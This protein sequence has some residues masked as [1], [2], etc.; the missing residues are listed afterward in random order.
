MDEAST[1]CAGGLPDLLPILPFY[2]Y[3]DPPRTEKVDAPQASTQTF[4][5]QWSEIQKPTGAIV[6][7]MI[8]NGRLAQLVR[9]W[10]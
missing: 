1:L 10:C 6:N 2:L 5:D 9:A 3:T 4:S 7:H 8:T